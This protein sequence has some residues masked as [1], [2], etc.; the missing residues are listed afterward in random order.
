MRCW[1]TLMKL[2]SLFSVAGWRGKYL[3]LVM[4][5]SCLLLTVHIA[6]HITL[7]SFAPYGKLLTKFPLLER[8]CHNLG[9][10]A[11]IKTPTLMIIHYLAP[12]VSDNYIEISLAFQ[13]SRYNFKLMCAINLRLLNIYLS[14]CIR[15]TQSARYSNSRI[16]MRELEYLSV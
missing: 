11:Y 7:A 13:Y 6:W 3:I 9:F 4:T 12:E 1:R 5:L 14:K 8:I 16:S 10:V 2:K 15:S